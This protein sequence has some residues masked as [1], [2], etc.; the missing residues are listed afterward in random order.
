MKIGMTRFAAAMSSSTIFT[1]GSLGI[2]YLLGAKLYGEARDYFVTAPERVQELYFY[3][4][5]RLDELQEFLAKYSITFE[6]KDIENLLSEGQELLN[7]FVSTVSGSL[8]NYAKVVPDLFLFY[9][10]FIVAVFLISISMPSLKSSLLSFFASG[11]KEKVEDVIIRLRKTVF[12]FIQAQLILSTA[13]YIISVLGLLILQVEYPFVISFFIVLVDILP[14]LGT[15]SF[16]IPWAL[17]QVV[18][19]DF[20]LAFGLV[21]LFLVITV[22]RKIIEPKVLGDSIGIGPLSTLVSIYVGFKLMGVV[23]LFLGPIVVIL[24]QTL[25]E[26]GLLNIKIKLD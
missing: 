23:G 2:V 13:T 7:Q 6:D 19:G 15:G 1:L 18:L 10:V 9:I 24:V 5:K 26:V 21:I 20:L 8:L 3:S 16:I 4:L 14:I 25:K 22:F 12:G 11:T 17:Y